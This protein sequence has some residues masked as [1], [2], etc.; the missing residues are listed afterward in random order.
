MRDALGEPGPIMEDLR[1]EEF[2]QVPPS[3]RVS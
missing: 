3:L 1:Y 2:T